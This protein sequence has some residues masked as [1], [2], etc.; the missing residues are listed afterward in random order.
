MASLRITGRI[1]DRHIGDS[2]AARAINTNGL[3]WGVLDMKIGDSGVDKIMCI[4][5]LGLGLA[6]IAAFAIPPT[7]TVGVQ[8][9]TRGALNIDPGAFNLEQWANPF[10]VAPGGLAF[11]DNL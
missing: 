8:I 11:E 6:T 10:L 3:N 9:S 7:S 4:E 1:I 5:E 2:Q